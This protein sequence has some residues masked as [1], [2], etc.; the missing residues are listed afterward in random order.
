MRTQF[1]S[2]VSHELKTPLTAIRIFAETLRMGRSKNAAKQNEYLDTI[3]SESERLSRLINNV[4]DFSKIEKGSRNYRL[5]LASLPDLVSS[6]AGILEYP[7]KQQG[8]KLHVDIQEDLPEVM[9]DR[10]SIEQAILN[11][12]NNAI[13]YSG[14]S[15]EIELRLIRNG[16]YA[17]IQVQDFGIGI[18]PAE[19]K[20][21]FEDYYR[22]DS[23][24]ESGTV[25]TGIGLALASHI[26][27]GHNGRIEVESL[28]GEGS[29]FSIFLKLGEQM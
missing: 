22:V 2:S 11:L 25:G 3:V 27:K 28:P 6:C 9:I 7:L 14:N 4:L 15:R 20:R 17:V 5:K 29:T 21:I 16:S 1:V 12:L 13:K 19:H 23:A 26:V 10:D 24:A 8:F 18:D